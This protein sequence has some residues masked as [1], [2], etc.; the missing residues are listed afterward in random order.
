MLSFDISDFEDEDFS[1]SSANAIPIFGVRC[2]RSEVSFIFFFI[3]LAKPICAH[4]ILNK[5][6][7]IG[8][9][10]SLNFPR[11]KLTPTEKR[12]SQTK[13]F[14]FYSRLNQD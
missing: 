9:M 3:S 1:L 7:R 12:F 14:L 2:V 6:V 11:G 10:K 4:W 8:R 13:A 5:E